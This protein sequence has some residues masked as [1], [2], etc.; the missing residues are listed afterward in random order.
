MDRDRALCLRSS[1]EWYEAI[2]RVHG[3]EGAVANAV[4]ACAGSPPP[5]YSSVIT[6]SRDAPENQVRI[7]RGLRDSLL[8]PFS[9]KDS[10][11]LLD[12][13]P[14]GFRVLFEA[15]WTRRDPEALPPPL[16][17]NRAAW[18]RVTDPFEL[19]HWEAAWSRNGSPTVRRVFL[20][21]LLANV[22]VS[23]LAARRGDRIVAG[24]VAHRSAE[25]VGF[26]NFFT[27]DPDIDGLL[28]EAVGEV[29]RFAP[30]LPVVGYERGAA[31]ARVLRLGFRAVGPLRVWTTQGGADGAQ[32]PTI[33]SNPP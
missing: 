26:S 20:P 11:A 16:E 30:G 6:L 32:R 14:L 29:S 10:F 15:E 24:C 19:E 28:A 4:W 23:V 8:R 9:V 7:I 1:L 25:T 13:V 31:L 12:L 5:Y 17:S 22:A 21:G 27:E 3:L 18:R 2:L 33:T